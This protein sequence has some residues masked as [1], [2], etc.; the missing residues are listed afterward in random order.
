MTSGTLSPLA[1]F[2]AEL[3]I[4]FKQKLEN[5]HVIN[6]EQVNISILRRGLGSSEFKFDYQ[7][8][9]NHEMIDDLS[10]TIAKLCTRVP[11]G[12]LIFFPS[13][14]LLNDTYDRWTRSGGLR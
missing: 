13:Y 14:K 6:T 9:D 10:S 12:I 4:E 7:S 2:E 8:R 1:S 11:G 3:Q 5:P